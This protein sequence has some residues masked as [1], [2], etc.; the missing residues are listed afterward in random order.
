MKLDPAGSVQNRVG[1]VASG[2]ANR[3]LG[4]EAWA[5][6]K[7]AAHAGRVFA[8]AVGPAMAGFRI[9]SDGALANAPL[10]GCEPDL[11]LTLS[12]LDLPA[13]LADPR[14][15]NEYVKEAGDAAL[16]GT[17]KELA[18][19]LPWFVEQAFA[20]ALGPVAGQRLADAGRHL[21]AFPAHAAARLS[22]SVGRYARDEAALVIGDDEMRVF[23]EQVAALSA[24]VDALDARVAALTAPR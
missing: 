23:A 16:G 19:T 12:P 1:S 3:T 20:R 6:E 10:A 7:L 18:Q 8:I 15:W 22:E 24:R 5:R 9:E 11:R 2:I 17:L 13:F 14:Q 21:L 4:R